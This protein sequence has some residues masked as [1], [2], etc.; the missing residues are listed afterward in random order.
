[1]GGMLK[2]LP[3]SK[4]KRTDLTSPHAAGTLAAALDEVGIGEDAA[5]RMQLESRLPDMDFERFVA[6][7]GARAE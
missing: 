4:W 7:I 2:D 5:G 6:A 1:M 3:R